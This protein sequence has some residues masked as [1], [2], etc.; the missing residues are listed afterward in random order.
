[1]AA[2]LALVLPE[3]VCVIG[4]S[5]IYTAA[6][7]AATEIVVTEVDLDVTGDAFAPVIGPEWA[8]SD[9]GEWQQSKTGDTAFRIRRY[10]R[11]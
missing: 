4:G 8:I 2:A 11:A 9:D 6:L 5:Q 1:V 3:P 10:R 7:P